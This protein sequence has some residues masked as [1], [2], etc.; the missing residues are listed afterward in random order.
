M[1]PILLNMYYSLLSCTMNQDRIALIFIEC[2]ESALIKLQHI[3]IQ[4]IEF[5]S[6]FI[7][8]YVRVYI[9]SDTYMVLKERRSYLS[10]VLYLG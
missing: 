10:R 3:C 5:C 8:K 1:R 7:F 4:L 2:Y 9:Q 6:H